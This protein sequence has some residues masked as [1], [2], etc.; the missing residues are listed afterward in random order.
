MPTELLEE[1]KAYIEGV[2]VSMDEH[3]G[4]RTFEEILKA[5]EVCDLYFR[6]MKLLEAA[7]T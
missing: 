1:V 6:V 4:S 5:G 3:R 2:E 7:K